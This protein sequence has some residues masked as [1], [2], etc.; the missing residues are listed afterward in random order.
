MRYLLMI[1]GDEGAGANM[2][3]EDGQA[4]DEAYA[5]FTKN[6]ADRGILQ[7]GE[8]LRP[9]SD[10]TTVRVRNGEILTTDGPFAETKEQLG[11]YYLVECPDIDEAIAVAA[12][13]PGAHHGSVEVRP[14]WEM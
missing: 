11:G 9:T 4:M 3:E 2:S 7:A 8:R 14:I 1:A 13:I 5:E 12:L 6:I 10:A